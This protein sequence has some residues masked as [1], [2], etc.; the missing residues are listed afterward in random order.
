MKL[1]KSNKEIIGL[2]RRKERRNNKNMKKEEWSIFFFFYFF[3]YL[4]VTSVTDG[5]LMSFLSRLYCLSPRYENRNLKT[6]LYWKNTFCTT[7]RNVWKKE[8]KTNGE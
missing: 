7:H 1:V 4:S 8:E 3:S 6:R 2:Y 5:F